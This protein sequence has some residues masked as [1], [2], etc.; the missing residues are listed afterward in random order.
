MFYLFG[1]FLF[2]V[3]LVELFAPTGSLVY[4]ITFVILAFVSWGVE[5][6]P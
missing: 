5:Q 3:G 4:G 2:L 6:I 1:I